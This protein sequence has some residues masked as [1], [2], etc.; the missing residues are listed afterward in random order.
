[1]I[2][3]L[4]FFIIL[5]LP[6][7]FALNIGDNV[8]LVITRV[9]VPVIFLLW[10]I[11]SLAQRKIWIANRAQTWLLLSFLFLSALSLW[12]GLGWDKGIRKIVYLFSIVPVYFVA[13]DLA[14]DEKF[15]KRLAGIVWASGVLAAVAGLSQF[16]LP[17]VFGLDATLKLWKKLA[18][19]FLGS[20]FGKL[21]ATNPSW[22]VNVSGKT[23]MRAFGFFPDPHIFSFFVSLCF[24]VGLGLFFSERNNFLKI[25]YLA[26]IL[27]MVLAI[28]F[29]FSRGAY[30]GII[31]GSLFY[32]IFLLKKKNI[33][34]K[35]AIA[36]AFMLAIVLIFYQQIIFQRLASAFNPKEGSN[37]ERL[38][39]WRQAADIIQDH[40]LF[41]VGLGNYS[42]V[43]DPSSGERSS[44]Y[45]HNM[46]LDIAAE[47]G[48]LNGIVFLAL[49]AVGIWQAVAAKD[50]LGTGAASGLVYF[51]VHGIFDTPL[52]SPQVLV[53]FL[54]I[55]ALGITPT[56]L[57]AK[58][59]NVKTTA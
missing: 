7:Q 1:M 35:V 31:A 45:A 12:S 40:P 20:S 29:S 48:V 6:L 52:W 16:V 14:R 13:A 8:D 22:L 15:R 19:F 54:I 59:A 24:F 42:S 43:V 27:L 17:F 56:K 39:N 46:F 5:L 47:T 28:L 55:V 38:Q 57:K 37:V 44:I 53:I 10:L 18:I 41:G 50:F 26:G 2:D 4:F 32:V 33:L 3:Y 11:R 58:S 49:L 23:L 51:F 30:L 25:A 36:G 34:G 9:L 21:V